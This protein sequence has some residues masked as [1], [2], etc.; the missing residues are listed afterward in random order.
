MSGS[1]SEK[2]LSRPINEEGKPL[3]NH[4]DNNG[5]LKKDTLS[6]SHA[7]AMSITG[8]APTGIINWI[9]IWSKK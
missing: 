9:K 3:L 2:S 1:Y 4:Q 7:L 6:L 5:H 8:I